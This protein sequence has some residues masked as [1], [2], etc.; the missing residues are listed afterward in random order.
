MRART[1]TAR[2]AASLVLAGALLVGTT[3]CTFLSTQATLIQYDPSDG[4]GGEV[5]DVQLRN[6]IGIISDDGSAIS[7]LLTMVNSGTTAANVEVQY[8]SS[9]AKTSVQKQVPVGS[10]ATFGTTT[11]DEKILVLDPDVIA[12]GLLPVYFQYGDNPGTQ[13]MVPVLEAI[14]DYAELQPPTVVAQQ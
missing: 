7:L 13:L 10:V 11:D 9:G 8:E 6:V 2:A 12:G 5:G 14:G 3:G 1:I 4:I